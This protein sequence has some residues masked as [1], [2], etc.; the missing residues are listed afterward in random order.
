M[1]DAILQATPSERMTI[2][3]EA[4]GVRQYQFKKEQ[5][6]NK[7]E[8][9]KQN[10]VRVTDLLNEI[11]PRLNSLK[12]QANKAQKRGAVE[13][14]LKILQEN[15]FGWLWRKLEM[16]EADSKIS[17][18]EME[19]K[20]SQAE[21]EVNEI[22][23]KLAENEENNETD[24]GE[25]ENLQKESESAQEKMNSFQRDLSIAEGR[26][27]VENERIEKEKIEKLKKLEEAPINLVYVKEK[28]S[29]FYNTFENLFSLILKS[30]KT[31][32]LS[33]LKKE[34]G[35]TREL[36]KNIL[37]EIKSGKIKESRITNHES[38]VESQVELD[39]L[40]LAKEKIGNELVKKEK[41]YLE[42]K[43]KITK[44]NR[45][46]QERRK[47]FFGLERELREKQDRFNQLKDG[48]NLVKIDLAKFE[49]RREDLKA[50]IID[51]LGSDPVLNFT[52]ERD[53]KKITGDNSGCLDIGKQSG[54]SRSAELIRWWWRNIRRPWKDLNFCQDSLTT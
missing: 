10:L 7:L 24:Q 5:S 52:K 47:S 40:V 41:E 16:D 25:Y 26:I 31:G 14:E 2:F 30:D 29:S 38:K 20:I 39:K 3:E 54:W 45:A 37:D 1:A 32:D 46:D 53:D 44:L 28:I 36:L 12:R 4:T 13:E 27:Q 9:T 17:Q 8:S 43:N 51:E 11:E 19:K 50:E 21:K 34:A 23:N 6:L 15:L 48:Y 42:I 22:K 35:K 33:D 49:V 18:K